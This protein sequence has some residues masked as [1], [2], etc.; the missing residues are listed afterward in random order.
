LLEAKLHVYKLSHRLK[1]GICVKIIVTKQT[2]EYK[3]DQRV[4]IEKLPRVFSC[5]FADA[6]A[7]RVKQKQKIFGHAAW[8]VREGIEHGDSGS[9]GLGKGKNSKSIATAV[10]R[11]LY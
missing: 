10:S 9:K 3:T 7:G 11:G 8:T 2:N 1:H 5:F 6:K 4:G